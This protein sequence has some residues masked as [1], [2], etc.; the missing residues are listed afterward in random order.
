M[1][2]GQTVEF[3]PIPVEM[4]LAIDIPQLVAGD[5]SSFYVSLDEAADQALRQFVP[6]LTDLVHR[7][8]T[9]AGTAIDV[10][11]EPLSHDLM[12][13]MLDVIDLEFDEHENIT[14]LVMYVNPTTAE[15]IRDLPPPTP[16]QAQ[17]YQGDC[18][19]NGLA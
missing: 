4:N 11:G 8:S 10:Q 3:P 2:N 9:A 7:T 1:A 14:N 15:R 6:S 18:H 12:I 16:E 5:F 17:A 13:K 19:T